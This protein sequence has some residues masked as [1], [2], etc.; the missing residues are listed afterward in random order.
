[1]P[2]LVPRSFTSS[3]YFRTS[4]AALSL[5]AGAEVLSAQASQSSP[6]AP[7]SDE[8]SIFAPLKLLPAPS[9]TRNG[10]GTPGAKYWQNRADYALKATLDTASMSVRGEMTLKYTNNSPDKL[11]VIWVHTEQNRFRGTTPQPGD[12]ARLKRMGDQYGYTFTSFTQTV[13]G[14]AVTVKL[15]EQGTIAK[16][17]LAEPLKP[18]Q[19][20]TIK[21]EYNF[22]VPPGGN[23]MGRQGRL[24]G[25]AQ[26]YPRVAVYDDVTGWNIA[27]Y[28]G[29]GEFYTDYGDY[30]LDVTVPA[31]YIVAATGQLTNPKDVLPATQQARLQAAATSDTIVRI[32][33]STELSDGTARPTQDGMLTWK[34][35]STNV[36]DAVWAASPDYQWDAIGWKGKLMQAYYRPAA[37]RTWNEAADMVRFA[38][39]EY[40]SRWNLPYPYPQMSAVEGPEGGIEYPMVTFVQVYPN[41]PLQYHVISHETGHIWMPM[42]VGSNERMHAWMDEGINQFINSFSDGRYSP[43]G[44]DQERRAQAYVRDIEKALKANKDAV[45]DVPVD[46]PTV[47][48]GYVAYSKPAGV[49]HILRRDVLGPEV[50]DSALRVYMQRWAYKHPTP[51][52]FYR[53]MEDVSG[54]KLD[55]FW[56]QFLYEAPVFD[57]GVGAVTQSVDGAKT[58]VKVTYENAGRGV[59]PL[60]VRFTFSDNTTQDVVHTADVWRKNAK[61][62]DAMYTFEGKTVAKVQL[63]PEVRLIDVNRANNVKEVGAE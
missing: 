40:S 3:S 12:V 60:Y 33:T 24:Y 57:Q 22:V 4:V 26:W 58:N 10:N 51:A 28:H 54:Q 2:R 13:R 36:R 30:T 41:K 27:P 63:D 31:G 14:K 29:N 52:D 42:I 49:M 16:V 35:A 20:T 19:S 37:A 59:L 5:V 25:I 11:D 43:A 53:T 55:W 45:V 48:R 46:G 7:A 44:G 18:G 9:S 1:M 21:A 17:T 39:D 23:R 15:D 61:S 47:N 32:I 34:F 38:I 62:Y 8:G 56:R 6:T 50:F